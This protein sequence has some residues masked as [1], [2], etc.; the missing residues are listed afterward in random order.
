MLNTISSSTLN[1]LKDVAENNNREWFNENKHLYLEAQ[2]NILQFLEKLIADISEF[3]E[4]ILKISAKKALF[5]IYRDV[6]FSLNKSPYK[7][8]FGAAL[9]FGKGGRSSGY[10]LHIEPGNSFIAGGVYMPEK[11]ILKKIRT[12]ISKNPD[13]FLKIINNKNFKKDFTELSQEDKLKRIPQGFDKENP[14]E[15][16]LKLKSFVVRYS[17]KDEDLMENSGTEKIA[18]IC[19]Q[20]KPLNDFIENT[21]NK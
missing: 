8:H 19:E 20:I 13:A 12:N 10:Y 1:F 5:R 15:D 16:Y 17:L 18:Q 21:I 9:G 4:E 11:E 2:E 6:R 7:N 3:D 14:M